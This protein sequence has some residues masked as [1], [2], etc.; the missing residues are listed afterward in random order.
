MTSKQWVEGQLSEC[1]QSSSRVLFARSR[2]RWGQCGEK[3]LSTPSGA[4][5]L[6]DKTTLLGEATLHHVKT[7]A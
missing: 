5:R 7:G 6:S 4:Y 2:G 3:G 1:V